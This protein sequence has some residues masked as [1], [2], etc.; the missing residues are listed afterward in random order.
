MKKNS[1]DNRLFRQMMASFATGVAVVTARNDEWGAFGITINSLTSVSLNPPLALFCLDKA[2]HLHPAFRDTGFFAFNL[3]AA[4]QENVSRH[5]A[6]RHH[7]PRPK[8]LWDR[9]QLD[10]PILRGTLGWMACR[11]VA[12]YKGGD[13]TIFLGEVV[14]LYRR[15]TDKK[16]LIYFHGRYRKLED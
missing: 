14:K 11:K 1:P 5:F 15:R 13:H 2:A 4:G 6:D 3:L 9:P 16:P 12:A 7:N 10:C 8:N